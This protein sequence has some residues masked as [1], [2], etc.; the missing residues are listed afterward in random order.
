MNKI[1]FDVL[2]AGEL[3][4]DIIFNRINK[5]PQIGEEQK[6]E[7]LNVTMGSSTAIFASN[8]SSLGLS[9]CFSGKVGN[10][11]FGE[12]V[13]STLE[14]NGVNTSHIII[15]PDVQTGA[16]VI[17]GIGDSRMMVTYPGAMEQFSGS[18][19]PDSLFSRCRH[20]HTSSIF[21]QPAL[22]NDLVSVLK[23]AKEQGM[24]TSM[25]T[26]WDPEETWDLGLNQL[27][28]HLD[29][30][31]PNEKEFLNIAGVDNLDEAFD[32]YSDTGCCLVIKNG[33]DGV[34]LKSKNQILRESALKISEFADA[35]GA[36]DSFNAGFIRAFLD[37]KPLDEC[38]KQGIRTATASLLAPGGTAGIE[39]F[40]QVMEVTSGFIRN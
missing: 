1:E 12:L 4:A 19:I 8:S 27:L 14:S 24:T 38:L 28:P 26:Q 34:T 5:M 3:N 13:T 40:K 36:G 6:A 30:F 20:F 22:K 33:A 29:F 21:F 25:D 31:M 39:S 15:D 2:V 16:T 10:D 18:D 35:I 37:S 11:S 32:K 17:L 7:E 23:R 9:V